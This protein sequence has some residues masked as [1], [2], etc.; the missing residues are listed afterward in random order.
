MLAFPFSFPRVYVDHLNITPGRL[1]IEYALSVYE[2][3]QLSVGGDGWLRIYSFPTNINVFGQVNENW[4]RIFSDANIT[5][6]SKKGGKRICVDSNEHVFIE[7]GD[8]VY[9][10]FNSGNITLFKHRYRDECKI[11]DLIWRK[12]RQLNLKC[13]GP[14]T[15]KL[16]A[17][18]TIKERLDSTFAIFSVPEKGK[19]KNLEANLVVPIFVEINNKTGEVLNYAFM[20]TPGSNLF[21]IE[22][23]SLWNGTFKGYGFGIF[24]EVEDSLLL[25][26]NAFADNFLDLV[27]IPEVYWSDLITKETTI[28]KVL[29]GDCETVFKIR[30]AYNKPRVLIAEAIINSK[31]LSIVSC[32]AFKEDVHTQ[33]LYG[34]HEKTKV[35]N[36]NTGEFCEGSL[37]TEFRNRSA[38][39]LPTIIKRD[40]VTLYANY[41]DFKPLES[42]RI[43]FVSKIRDVGRLT[44]LHGDGI[45]V[46]KGLG[47]L[48]IELTG[49]YR[50]FKPREAIDAFTINMNTDINRNIRQVVDG[51]VENQ[52]PLIVEG[53]KCKKY[54]W[55]SNNLREFVTQR[56]IPEE[57]FGE[58]LESLKLMERLQR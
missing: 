54:V 51:L 34:L 48:T 58:L 20:P 27:H 30:P 6:S 12:A 11:R 55:F 3:P 57:K 19:R 23:I 49:P 43:K 17:L 39:G 5:E 21:E 31:E 28:F 4:E 40:N 36:S 52:Q 33:F 38:N 46:E 42:G 41:S 32:V 44:V 9:V 8:R 47:R 13:T 10:D 2:N 37:V 53:K 24:N 22:T 56:E 25:N 1:P 18:A 15:N 50:N 29:Y 14:D 16:M 7:T 45:D 35:R 26:N